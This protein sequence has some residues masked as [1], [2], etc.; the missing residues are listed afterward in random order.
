MEAKDLEN[1]VQAIARQV[2]MTPLKFR[3]EEG[4]IVI[5]WENGQKNRYDL[6]SKSQPEAGSAAPSTALSDDGGYAPE[7]PKK[8]GKK[9]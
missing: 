7:P 5:V 6:L 2:Q 9:K 8:K 1:A 4:E 3:E